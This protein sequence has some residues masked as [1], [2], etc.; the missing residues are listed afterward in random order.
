MNKLNFDNQG[1]MEGSQNTTF[2]PADTIR[3]ILG[4]N[5]TQETF[6]T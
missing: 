3:H 1:L 6:S 2:L 4:E 5:L